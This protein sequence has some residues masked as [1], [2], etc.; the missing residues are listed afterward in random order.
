MEK[1]SKPIVLLGEARGENEA[2]IGSNFVGASGIELLR[3]LNDAGL[4][5]LTSEDNSYIHKFYSTG[6][7]NQIEMVW[8]LHP[9]L[10]RT[11]VLNFRPPGN[12]LESLCGPKAE[13]IPGFPSLTKSKYLRK[14]F[15]PELERLADELV[16]KDPNL[17]LCLGNAALWALCGTTGISKLRGT[18]RI[19]THTATGFKV[20]PTYHPAAVLRQWELRPVVIRDFIK[21]IKEKEYPD[22]RRPRREIWIEPSLDDVQEFYKS[23]I[24]GCRLLSVDIE[25]AGDQV[26]CIGFSPSP[27]RA[28]VIPF[29]DFRKRNRS[30]WPTLSDEREA[31]RWCA[32]I[33]GDPEIMKLFQN[34]MYDIAFLW[35]SL[36][37]P[38]FGAM[39]DTM[40]AHHALQPE[41]LKG[42]GF[43]GSVYTDEGPWKVERKKTSTIKKDE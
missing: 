2:R 9:E 3:M 22:V 6:D 27:E 12:S 34:G 5:I 26:T 39:E 31:V 1:S 33:N 19:S 21:A 42:L 35:R 32:K 28:L 36:H 30:Y 37:M 15:S 23:H 38:V 10:H 17:I 18:T 41:S 14:E 16:E 8:R 25:T 20:L 43:L 40:L 29:F 4:L 11:N 24:V 7:P 13:G